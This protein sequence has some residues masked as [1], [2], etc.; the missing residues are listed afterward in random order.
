[1]KAPEPNG[2]IKSWNLHD[3]IIDVPKS[4]LR[5]RPAAYG[6]VI[7]DKRILVAR[8]RNIEKYMLPGGGLDIGEASATAV[9]REIMEETGFDV[10]PTGLFRVL[11]NFFTFDKG[12]EEAFQ[13]VSFF[14]LCELVNASDASSVPKWQDTAEVCEVAW[15]E[16]DKLEKHAFM[17]IHD[18]V[19]SMF[20]KSKTPIAEV[21]KMLPEENR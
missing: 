18:R 11:E 9:R 19:I 3:E 16:I 21:M 13:G 7:H 14:Y 17:N 4:W 15:I 5:F 12:D 6:I 20:L 2:T 10:R 8:E 1:M